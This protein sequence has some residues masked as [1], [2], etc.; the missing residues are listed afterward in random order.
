MA[1]MKLQQ[2]GFDPRLGIDRYFAGRAIQSNKPTAGLETAEFQLNLFD[3][4]S[5]KGARTLAA[6]EHE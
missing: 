2:L 3:Q 1:A 6:P 4:F 5:G